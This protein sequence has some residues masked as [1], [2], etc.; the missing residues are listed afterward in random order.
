[1]NIP[2]FKVSMCLDFAAGEIKASFPCVS[3]ITQLDTLKPY[4]PPF[5]SY[6]I[7]ALTLQ[8]EDEPAEHQTF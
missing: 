5:Q 6:R 8:G 2:P 7:D 3:R 4:S 1:M